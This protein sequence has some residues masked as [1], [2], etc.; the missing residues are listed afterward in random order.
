MRQWLVGGAM[1]AMGAAVAACGEP[2]GATP[3]GPTASVTTTL[4]TLPVCD[5]S[6][7]NPLISH[8]FGPDE[9]KVVRGL[10][11]QI[12]LAGV[13]SGT[14]RD[15][16]FDVIAHIAANAQAGT[17]GDPTAAS[18]LINKVTACMFTDLAEFPATYPEDY[19][20]AITTTSPG[21]LGVR[22]GSSDPATDP[23]LSRDD[24]SGVAPPAGVT[25]A[26]VLGGNPAPARVAF[27]GRP[28]STAQSYDWKVLPRNATFAPPAIVGVCVDVNTATTSMLHEEHIGLLTF[29]DAYF[30]D[31]ASCGGLSLR[32]GL[33]VWSH[34]LAQIFLP[35]PLSASAVASGGI[36]G[37]TG[38][39]GSEFSADDVPS[40]SLAF[41]IQPPFTVTV[42]QT[43]TVQ[44]RATDPATGAV[45]GGTQVSI[46]A[47]NNNGV[48]KA[49]LGTTTQTTSNAGVA[50][51]GDLSFAPGSTGG[52]R[53][54][55]GGS[56]LGRS[57]IVVEQ[58]TSNK[59]NAK[60]VH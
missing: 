50:T 28:G 2:R 12:T 16:G 38:G 31:P 15:R 24:F 56:V 19:T 43:F 29:A 55:V 1:M 48:P 6:A 7:T 3:S 41:T 45:V 8:Y 39:I 34:R 13:G 51:F 33:S 11:D 26:A 18:D 57:A 49:L 46:L 10:I 47:V 52:Y 42:G 36:G 59:V 9:A 5:L 20:I 25:W 17:G 23:V 27:Y 30:L 35:R 40:V 54:V 14:A 4:T 37:S 58:V 44:L 60:P 32:T 21:G 53:L 22:G